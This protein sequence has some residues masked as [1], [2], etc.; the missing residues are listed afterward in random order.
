MSEWVMGDGRIVKKGYLDVFDTK[1]GDGSDLAFGC[2]WGLES[3]Q[4][5]Q[6]RV[7]LLY[8]CHVYCANTVPEKS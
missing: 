1:G 8:V 5:L 2:T 4:R 6:Q 3:L 7:E